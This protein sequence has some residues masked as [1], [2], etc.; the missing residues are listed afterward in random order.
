[1]S[2]DNTHV[3]VGLS[4]DRQTRRQDK[5]KKMIEPIPTLKPIDPD[6]VDML[7]AF[8]NIAFIAM[9]FTGVLGTIIWGFYYI[10]QMFN[11]GG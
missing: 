5:E 11:P 4:S 9:Y 8:R 6:D 1:M 3:S 7:R 2:S 10:Y